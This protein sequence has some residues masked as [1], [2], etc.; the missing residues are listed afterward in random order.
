MLPDL[1][2][3]QGQGANARIW[4]YGYPASVSFQTSSIYDFAQA[5]LHRVKDVRKDNNV[6]EGAVQ[7]RDSYTNG[8]QDRKIVWVC[9]SLGGLVLKQVG[10]HGPHT[11][12]TQS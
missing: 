11:L 1:I 7:F 6:S 9:H 5:L 8:R 3:S 4:T 10:C 12:I 2:R